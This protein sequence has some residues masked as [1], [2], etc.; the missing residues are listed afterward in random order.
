MAR[1]WF[2]LPFGRGRLRNPAYDFLFDRGPE[3]EAMVID[4]ETTGLDRRRDDI[5]SIAAVPIR[6]SRILASAAFQAV[7]RPQARMREDAIKIHGLRESDVAGGQSMADV[8]PELLRFIGG[9]PLVGYYLE[10]DVAMLNRHVRKLLGVGLPNPCIEVSA[11]Y[12]DCKYGDWPPDVQFD[13]GFD[14]MMRDLDLPI[15][16][17]HDAY[18][19]ALM[20]ATAYLALRERIERGLRLPR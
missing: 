5:V 2:S 4:C 8:L 12:Y 13:L 20:T 14:A 16:G 9:R 3:S 15:F 7:V 11:L 19:D 18:S 6:G 17:R 10:F 1:R